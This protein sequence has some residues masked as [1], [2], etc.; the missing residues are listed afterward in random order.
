MALLSETSP[1]AATTIAPVPRTHVIAEM[2]CSHDGSPTLACTIIDGAGAA[3]ADAIQFQMWKLEDMMVRCH[4]AFEQVKRLELMPADWTS[5][6]G[7][8]R[9]RWPGLQIIACVYEQ[10]AIDLAERIG[11]VA[12]KIHAADLAT[13]EL[14]KAVAATG[15]RID[16][17]VGAST[18][19]EIEAALG[20]IR[21]AGAPPVW[22]MYGYQLFPTPTAALDLAF[23]MKLRHLFE[24]PIGYQD[25]TAGGDAGAFWLPAAA[26]GMGVDILEKHITHDRS[27]KGADHEA[28]LDPDEF[29]RFVQMVRA[30]EAA[31]G[32]G[33]PRPFTEAE[34][35]YRVYSKKSLVA[36]HAL[37]AGT[38]LRAGDLVALRN[39]ELGL[40]P[41]RRA[42]LV[43]RTLKRAIDAQA[44]VTLADLT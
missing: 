43:G 23:M 2:A 24:L 30:I 40:P 14:I 19:A 28:A 9:G 29:A 33:R 35:K 36:R 10:G 37:P 8:V 22:L 1:S 11:V 4:P 25:H 12:Y 27:R 39:T 21:D 7:Y 13:P 38:M 31:R 44:L 20:W 15:R 41:S 32:T 3:G 16:L 42:E 5:L 17:S 6:A 18:I 26:L 34:L